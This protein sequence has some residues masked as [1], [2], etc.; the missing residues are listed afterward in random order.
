MRLSF[1]FAAVLSCDS[2]TSSEIAL[3][4]DELSTGHVNRLADSSDGTTLFP[5]RS[6]KIRTECIAKV[7]SG[8]FES[9]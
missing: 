7:V 9:A 8:T 1:L 4:K 6:V 2:M 3:I 5:W